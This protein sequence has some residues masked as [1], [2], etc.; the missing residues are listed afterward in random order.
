MNQVREDWTL[1]PSL[2]LVLQI[3][4]R[5]CRPLGRA[6]IE[7]EIVAKREIILRKTYKLCPPA[8]VR[9]FRKGQPEIGNT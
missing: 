3:H 2:P 6:E 9:I 5:G 8:T 1:A 4:M 7:C